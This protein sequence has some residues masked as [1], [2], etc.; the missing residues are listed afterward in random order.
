MRKETFI[1]IENPPSFSLILNQC[2]LRHY[3]FFFLNDT[4]LL[5]MHH[6]ENGNPAHALSQHILPAFAKLGFD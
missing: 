5:Q 6:V 1:C 2:S 3:L 4:L